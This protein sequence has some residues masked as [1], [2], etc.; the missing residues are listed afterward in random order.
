MEP[1]RCAFLPGA[2]DGISDG[3]RAVG[4]PVQPPPSRQTRALRKQPCLS[5]LLSSCRFSVPL[6]Y[7][8]PTPQESLIDASEDSQL[9]AAIRASLEETHY[10]SQQAR[11]D[12]RS[13]EDSDAEPFSDSE[14]L[15]SVDGSDE[16]AP[17]QAP[18]P[19][20]ESPARHRR[21]P[22]KESSHRKEESKKN[23]LEMP[24]TSQP[25]REGLGPAR[26]QNS[27]SRACEPGA[28]EHGSPAHPSDSG[29]G[30]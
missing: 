5:R 25:C 8:W 27:G 10:E 6:T 4:R 29:M 23:H 14:G 19:R 28:E 16:E 12:S 2:G 30:C 20:P 1:S 9:E 3:A 21:S 11:P 24:A 26:R 22:H 18:P 17:A 13:E 7:T 15:I